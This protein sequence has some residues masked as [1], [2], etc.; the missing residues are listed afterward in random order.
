MGNGLVFINPSEQL[1]LR[2]GA[3]QT[4]PCWIAGVCDLYLALNS[5]ATG[6]TDTNYNVQAGIKVSGSE[7]RQKKLRN[8]LYIMDLGTI[9]IPT[10]A[11][12]E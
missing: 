6:A 9:W 2:G 5:C 8:K 1:R 4:P 11:E 10:A 7:W 3:H 12:I